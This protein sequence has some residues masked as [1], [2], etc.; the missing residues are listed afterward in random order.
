META[1]IGGIEQSVWFRGIDRSNPALIL[2]HGGPGASEA[3]LFR[4]YDAD[5]ERRFLV[6]Y[7]DQRGAGRSF[8][9]DIPPQSMTIAQFER[10]LDQLVDLVRRRFHKRKVVLLAHS[11]GAVLGTRYAAHHPDKVAA[12][13][14]VAPLLDKRRQDHL[15]YR[16]A[17]MHARQRDDRRAIDEL[18]AIG[19]A[20]RTV[21]DDLRLGSIVERYGG[22]FYRNRLSTGKLI[23]A[24]LQTDEADIMDLVRFGRGNRFSLHSLWPEYSHV[25]LRRITSFAMPVFFLLGRG[26]WHVPSV[27]AAEHFETIEA[28]VKRLVWFEE[29]AHNPPFEEAKRFVSVMTEQ[30]LP[31]AE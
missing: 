26:D 9:D 14:A 16:F 19:P 1:D 23:C 15:S 7:W 25:D 31:L 12:Y 18:E 28:P 13:V 20:P 17:V 22:T 4:H 3:A 11:W 29:S 6:V 10:D 30:V 21:D 24:A 8:D 5:L 27:V 2:L